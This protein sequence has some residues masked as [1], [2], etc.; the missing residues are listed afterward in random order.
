MRETSRRENSFPTAH[1]A[2]CARV[3]LT[4]VD[5]DERGERRRCVHCD[6]VVES[7]PHWIGATELEA[8]GYQIGEPRRPGGGCGAGG[9]CATRRS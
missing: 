8:A 3:V 7:E 9:G 2:A 5:F 1:C 6:G 4:C